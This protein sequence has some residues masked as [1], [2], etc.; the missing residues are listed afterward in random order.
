M[1]ELGMLGHVPNAMA[2]ATEAEVAGERSIWDEQ[3][4][5]EFGEALANVIATSSPSF[6]DPM[7]LLGNLLKK[8]TRRPLYAGGLCVMVQQEIE[9]VP[10]DSWCHQQQGELFNIEFGHSYVVAAWRRPG[11]DRDLFKQEI[12]ALGLSATAASGPW[13]LVAADRYDKPGEIATPVTCQ[14]W[15]LW[16]RCDSTF[17]PDGKAQGL[18]TGRSPTTVFTASPRRSRKKRLAT[19][20]FRTHGLMGMRQR[21]SNGTSGSSHPGG[22]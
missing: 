20:S 1:I 14:W 11:G 5:P 17:L 10:S 18:W 22:T 4:D 7:T 2:M 9:C 6:S 13:L 21:R 3:Y 15:P 19:T 16:M 8:I 12:C